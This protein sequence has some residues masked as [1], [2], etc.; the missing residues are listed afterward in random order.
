MGWKNWPSWLRGMIIGLGA[1]LLFYIFS[2]N[3]GGEYAENLA[4]IITV[5]FSLIG[6]CGPNYKPC[7]EE[8]ISLLLITISFILTILLF[9]LIGTIIGWIY[10]KIKSKNQTQNINQ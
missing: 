3:I 10:G 2:Y 6:V 9:S 1:G 4:F 8:F 5:Y 7:S